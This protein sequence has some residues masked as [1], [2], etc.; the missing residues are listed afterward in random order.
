MEAHNDDV[1]YD[2][3]VDGVVVYDMLDG[4]KAN[5]ELVCVYTLVIYLGHQRSPVQYHP[6]MFL[7][8]TSLI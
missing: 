3:V 1:V 4:V 2:D 5:G 7:Y 8:P 6:A